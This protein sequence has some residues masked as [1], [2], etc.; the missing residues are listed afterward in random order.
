MFGSLQTLRS[1]PL[2]SRESERAAIKAY[3]D[4]PLRPCE[5][6]L[7]PA[8][9]F[10]IGGENYYAQTRNPPYWRR[11]EG[12]IDALLVREGVGVRLQKVNARLAPEGL[13]L[14]L[15]DA[16]RPRAV[17]AYFHDQWVPAELR[18]R[19]PD[20]DDARVKTEVRRYWSA[21]S[22]SA[23]R[24][25]PHATGGAVDITLVWDDGRPLW[26]GGLFDDAS[27]I[28][29]TDW[30]E[31]ETNVASFSDEEARANRRLLY[32]LMTEEGFASLP[33]EWWHFSYGDQLWAAMTG[34]EHAIYGEAKA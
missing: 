20:W 33:N 5:E 4:W 9:A 7:M 31:D 14:F 10:G 30:L 6:R 34:A 19:H 18:R 25:A 24:P 8:S 22:D 26:M 13:R 21:P 16:W 32:W 23:L 17:Q 27:H 29:H 1:K 2:P 28:S 11:I 12:A 15:H 3:R